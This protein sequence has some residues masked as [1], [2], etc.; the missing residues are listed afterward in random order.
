VEPPKPW[1]VRGL[2]FF[3]GSLP[4][5]GSIRLVGSQK[6]PGIF[7]RNPC[8]T[9]FRT[10]SFPP[11]SPVFQSITLASLFPPRW[12]CGA[13]KFLWSSFA[14][15]ASSVS[16]PPDFVKRESPCIF[17][18]PLSISSVGRRLCAC[19]NSDPRHDIHP[20][21]IGQIPPSFFLFFFEFGVVGVWPPCSFTP[22]SHPPLHRGCLMIFSPFS[23]ADRNALHLPRS[24]QTPLR[25]TFPFSLCR[26]GPHF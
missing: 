15:P 6:R 17:T 22:P 13:M 5:R 8:A 26:I 4:F 24:S 9:P 14:P 16:R 23:F 20:S 10:P 7:C 3:S 18:P 21:M 2:S 12:H 19:D 25:F 1:S 11:H